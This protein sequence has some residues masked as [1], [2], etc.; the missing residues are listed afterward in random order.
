M[1]NQISS[2]QVTVASSHPKPRRKSMSIHRL[3]APAL[4]AVATS[5]ALR[6]R[7]ARRR[8]Q[9][10]AGQL[11]GPAPVQPLCG[12]RVH[13]VRGHD[14]DGRGPGPKRRRSRS[15]SMPPA[16]TPTTPI[17]TSTCARATSSTSRTT[18]PSRFKS[19]KVKAT[20]KGPL[21]RDRNPY[22]AR[23]GERPSRSRCPTWA[24]APTRGQLARR[25][26]HCDHAQ[27]QGLRH[28]L[29]QGAG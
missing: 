4:L 2:S 26:L 11:P 7:Y 10:L 24:P 15:P 16:S 14:R 13:H 22:Y 17:A 1:T 21:L 29:E 19:E 18:R 12:G 20:G 5:P 9:P 28:Q 27:P 6:R 3:F 23:R 25:V 8:S